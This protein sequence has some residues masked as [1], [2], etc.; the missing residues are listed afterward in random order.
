MSEFSHSLPFFGEILAVSNA[1][2]WAYSV[3][4]FKMSGKEVSPI[5]L[6]IFKISIGVVLMLVVSMFMPYALFPDIGI[7]AYVVLAMSGI[8]GIGLS[9]TLFFR[10]LN[11][12]G[13]S[14]CAIVEC[15]YSPFIILFSFIFL[16]ERLTFT[17]AIGALLVISSL[18]LLSGEGR[19][20]QIDRKS[21]ISGIIA[22]T[23]SMGTMGFAIV[24]VKPVLMALP[25]VWVAM[26]RMFFGVVALA[27]FS[28]FQS[29]RRKTWSIFLPQKIWK[30]ALPACFLG[31]FITMLLWVGS[32]KFATANIAA[33]LTQL[34]VVFTVFFAFIILK[35]PLTK[36]KIISVILAIFGSILV[37]S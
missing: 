2:I 35:E 31:S 27:L 18:F 32:F 7:H 6:N 12:L 20:D 10:A 30:V 16:G 3:I 29:D 8:L 36:R 1:V 13:A 5:S 9:D 34:N 14:R 23:L 26:T 22:G 15:L 37:I 4:L 28:L 25:V 24:I 19:K 33:V 21:L 11:I 17:S